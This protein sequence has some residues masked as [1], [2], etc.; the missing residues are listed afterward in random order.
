M[1]VIES[2]SR[3][4]TASTPLAVENREEKDVEAGSTSVDLDEPAPRDPNIVDWD[5]P[6]DPANPQNWSFGKKTVT[7]ACVSGLTFVTYVS[8]GRASVTP[9]DTN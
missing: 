2:E 6:D 7:V 5:G 4:D 8:L 3:P 9:I 1:G